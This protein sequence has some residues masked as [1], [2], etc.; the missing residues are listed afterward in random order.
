MRHRVIMAAE[1]LLST[2]LTIA[3]I[4]TE[5]GFYDQTTLTRHFR[6]HKGITP[7]KFRKAYG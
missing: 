4:A 6:K 1:Y 3:E 2:N 7:Y 5:V